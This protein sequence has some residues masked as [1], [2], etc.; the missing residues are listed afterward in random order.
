MVDLLGYTN[1]EILIIKC[2]IIHLVIIK[3]LTFYLIMFLI[4]VIGLLCIDKTFLCC[5][6][7]LNLI[8]FFDKKLID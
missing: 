1:K 3:I 2:H 6:V 7:Y 8:Y 5:I 4:C